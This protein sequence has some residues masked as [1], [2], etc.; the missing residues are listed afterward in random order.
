MYVAMECTIV[1][2][3]EKENN[4]NALTHQIKDFIL[5]F[6]ETALHSRMDQVK[7]AHKFIARCAGS[8][9]E[10]AKTKT[11]TIPQNSEARQ[12]Q[13]P[14]AFIVLQQPLP[15]HRSQLHILIVPARYYNFLESRELPTETRNSRR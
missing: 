3:A 1:Q 5:R 12:H 10:Q 8:D 11:T 13:S 6:S 15:H 2:K 9:D 4:S 14:D 7:H